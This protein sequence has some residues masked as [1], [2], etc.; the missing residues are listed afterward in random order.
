MLMLSSGEKARVYN[1]CGQPVSTSE[2]CSRGP[3]VFYESSP[4]DLHARQPFTMSRAPLEDGSDTALDV[5]ALD[6]EMIYSTAGFT[7]ARV[8]VVDGSGE[9]VMDEL[10]KMDD[11]VEVMYVDI[12]TFIAA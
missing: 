8:S 9:K 4:G 12:F 1:C 3:H 5:L 2:G 10:V 11:G 6:C 7:C